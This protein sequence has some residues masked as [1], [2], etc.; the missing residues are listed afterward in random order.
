MNL[1]PYAPADLET[2]S[3]PPNA[4]RRFR[5]R[6]IPAGIIGTIGSI[7][8]IG[9]LGVTVYFLYLLLVPSDA[10]S[11][12]DP[13]VYGPL[14]RFPIATFASGLWVASAVCIWH[15]RYWV[16]VAMLLAGGVIGQLPDMILDQ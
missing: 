9:S 16:G 14:V 5:L 4:P 1:N 2:P 13:R 12:S 6:L 7:S 11:I 8:F 3:G 15:R 10:P